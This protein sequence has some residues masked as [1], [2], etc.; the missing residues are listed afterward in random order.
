MIRHIL[1][2]SS[3][4]LL[5]VCGIQYI[6]KTWRGYNLHICPCVNKGIRDRFTNVLVEEINAQFPDKNKTLLI[7]SHCSGSLLQEAIICDKLLLSGY[8]VKIYCIDHKYNNRVIKLI[9]SKRFKNYICSYKKFQIE[10]FSSMKEFLDN[11]NIKQIDILIL[12]DPGYSNSVCYNELYSA[13]SIKKIH[14]NT[15]LG[16]LDRKII[17]QPEYNLFVGNENI[18]KELLIRSI[19]KYI[20]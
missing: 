1:Y 3:L 4:V 15:I 14:N 19:N 6:I 9:L 11:N 7:I 5:L 16:I 17:F 2:T 8:S 20:I 10:L 13:I 12:I 18:S